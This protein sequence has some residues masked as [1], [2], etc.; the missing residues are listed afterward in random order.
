MLDAKS[1][2]Q[3]WRRDWVWPH[4]SSYMHATLFYQ[5]KTILTDTLCAFVY[6]EETIEEGYEDGLGP[7]HVMMRLFD[8][9]TGE[10]VH[11]GDCWQFD[12]TEEEFLEELV[13]CAVGRENVIC[14]TS[15]VGHHKSGINMDKRECSPPR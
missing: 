4:H 5:R 6:Y 12:W 3:I 14:V 2:N 7:G 1:G 11:C 13:P 10:E 9:R 15:V 8:V